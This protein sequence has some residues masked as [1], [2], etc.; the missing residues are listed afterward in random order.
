[1]IQ[2]SHSLS[3]VVPLFQEE[4][5]V[6]HLQQG[7]TRFR[8]IE[9]RVRKVDFVLVDDGSTDRTQELLRK[10]FAGWP[11]EILRHPT[12]QGLTAALRTGSSAAKGE[13]VAWLDSDLTY[14][15]EVLTALAAQ[16]DAGADV[17]CAS[18]YHPE[19]EV[20]GV[21]RWRLWLSQLA[22]R[23]YRSLTAAPLHTFTCMVRVYRREVLARC[24]MTRGGF[25]GVTEVLLRALLA[26]YRI[27]ETPAVLKRRRAGV[28]KMRT[29]RVGLQHLE[30]MRSMRRGTF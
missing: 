18:C 3:V 21:P 20:V 9:E 30:L 27:V 1:M 26:G 22:S 16:I 14:E 19:G 8:A 25:L 12:N 24:P 17:A 28:S 2:S 4:S 29:W 15:P 10:H 11:A 7:L 23:R 6:E 13:L 5:G